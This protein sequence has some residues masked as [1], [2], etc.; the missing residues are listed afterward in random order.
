M[1]LAKSCHDLDWIRHLLGVPCRSVSSFGS[2]HHFRPECRPPGAAD[3]CLECGVEADCP[4]SAR[5]IYLGRVRQ[6]RTGWPVSVVADPATEASIE[7]ALRTGPYG[8]CVYACD[9]DVVDHQVVAMEFAGGRSA[10]FT[11]TAFAGSHYG[12]T[13]R[14]F[15]TRGELWGDSRHIEHHDFLT[16]RVERID[17]AASDGTIS[18]GHGGG[19]EGIVRAF[20]AAVASGDRRLVLTDADETFESH[21]IVFAA[22]RARTERRVVPLDEVR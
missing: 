10:V 5:R 12:R 1:L 18:G 17:T 9:N 2:L 14:L 8:R 13:T 22:E 6:G 16:D 11:M 20:T 7:A 15:G 19:D 3:R 21:R 4:Y